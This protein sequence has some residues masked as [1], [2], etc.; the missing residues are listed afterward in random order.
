MIS[1]ASAEEMRPH[2]WNIYK[3]AKQTAI[4]AHRDSKEYKDFL[5]QFVDTEDYTDLLKQQEEALKN[6]DGYF[7]VIQTLLDAKIK[8]SEDEEVEKHILN[9][10]YDLVN[11]YAVREPYDITYEMIEGRIRP[12][13]DDKL[14]VTLENWKELVLE[15]YKIQLEDR[16]ETR[17]KNW[18][19][20][21]MKLDLIG[22]YTNSSH[23]AQFNALLATMTLDSLSNM[24]ETIKHSIDYMDLTIK[25]DE[26]L[27]YCE[28]PRCEAEAKSC[29]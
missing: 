27:D 6:V 25:K 21:K 14:E 15:N 29:N 7:E 26:E 17:Q 1:K 3:Q 4:D 8:K 10:I 9:L 24:E 16:I 22:Y 18:A 2:L 11:S 23:K 13:S 19:D 12:W 5:E 20:R 28:P